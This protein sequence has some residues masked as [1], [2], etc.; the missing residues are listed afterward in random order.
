[1]FKSLWVAAFAMV[2]CSSASIVQAAVWG[3]DYF[4][5]IPL[6]TQDGETVYFFD[7]LIKDKIVVINFIYTSCPDTC[8]LETAQLVKVQNI[9]GNRVGT[10]VYFY[11]ISIDPEIDTPLVL[12]EY[13][14][15]FGARW[16]FLTGKNEDIIE[17]RKKLG[18]YIEEIQDGSKNHNVSM[19]I[20][21]QKTGR[22]MT[23]SPFENPY[24]FADQLSAFRAPKRGFISAYRNTC[25][26]AF[27]FQKHIAPSMLEVE[28]SVC[29]C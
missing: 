28:V 14:E 1:M 26:F 27:E 16:T 29:N 21:N 9:L 19:I 11:S 15:M 13:K 7:D 4:P 23:R 24:V 17:L 2:I 3:A 6:T 10:E 22:W 25:S 20:G 5:N 18:L 8:S 12:K